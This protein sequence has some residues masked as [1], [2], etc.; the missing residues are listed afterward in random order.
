MVRLRGPVSIF[1]QCIFNERTTYCSRLW[2][3]PTVA[4]SQ[5]ASK[6]SEYIGPRDRWCVSFQATPVSTLGPLPHL[7][8]QSAA[9]RRFRIGW[10]NSPSLPGISSLCCFEG[11]DRL[12]WKTEAS[13][14]NFLIRFTLR[15][16]NYSILLDRAELSST[17]CMRNYGA[18][19]LIMRIA[20]PFC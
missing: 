6:G 2:C 17:K 13:N 20:R 7:L 11:E 1:P 16:Q 15:L 10:S 3:R 12:R 9:K 18:P 14:S 4:A 8:D 5:D 19:E